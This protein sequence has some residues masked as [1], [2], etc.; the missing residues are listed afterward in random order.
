[1]V[2]Y[3]GAFS[4]PAEFWSV[5]FA[6]G[7]CRTGL[8]SKMRVVSFGIRDGEERSECDW[9]SSRVSL[10]DTPTYRRGP[11]GLLQVNTKSGA[12][13]GRCRNSKPYVDT[14]SQT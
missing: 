6:G 3:G 4:P 14:S 9:T 1:M 7:R 12:N 13:A 8:L 10:K 2:S 5:Y 11:C